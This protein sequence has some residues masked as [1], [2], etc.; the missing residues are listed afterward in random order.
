MEKGNDVAEEDPALADPATPLMA[1]HVRDYER[2]TRM[3]KI[4]AVVCFLIGLS[5]LMIL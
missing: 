2:F 3:F 4:G 1:A 5:V